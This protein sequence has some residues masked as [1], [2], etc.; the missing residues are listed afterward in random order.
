MDIIKKIGFS[1]I[2]K[3]CSFNRI[4]LFSWTAIDASIFIIPYGNAIDGKYKREI[5][6]NRV[7]PVLI[8]CA[9]NT[10]FWEYTFSRRTANF[11]F[12]AF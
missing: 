7:F 10:A 9:K 4:N 3:T 11:K 1:K 12:G 8:Y 6:V 5:K 2:K